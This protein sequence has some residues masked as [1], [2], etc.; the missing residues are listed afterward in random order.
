VHEFALEQA[1]AAPAVNRVGTAVID[2]LDL[3]GQ[4]D[5]DVADTQGLAFLYS[6]H[7]YRLADN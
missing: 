3:I 2:H 4:L 7:A 6:P 1:G 5:A